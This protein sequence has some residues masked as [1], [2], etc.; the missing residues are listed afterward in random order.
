MAAVRADC[1]REL[2]LRA[3]HRNGALWDLL[4]SSGQAA[5]KDKRENK[6]G[7]RRGRPPVF[8]KIAD[9]AVDVACLIISLLSKKDLTYRSF[10][11][12]LTS[13]PFHLLIPTI[14]SLLLLPLRQQ[15]Y[16]DIFTYPAIH[17]FKSV[18]F[19]DF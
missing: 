18:P 9:C 7:K 15:L 5:E 6:N 11:C 3:S 16:R 2:T 4:R 13:R 12:P 1:G 17:P 8:I 19:S 10:S 14:A